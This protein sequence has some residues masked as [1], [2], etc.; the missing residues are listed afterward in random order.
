[1]E[2]ITEKEFYEKYDIKER[3]KLIQ[4][5]KCKCECGRVVSLK[6]ITRHRKQAP[7]LI[8]LEKNIYCYLSILTC[9]LS[10]KIVVP[11][12]VNFPV[13]KNLF[14]IN[15]SNIDLIISDNSQKYN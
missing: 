3:V 7:H 1:M 9:F 11:L 4:T 6:N 8:F 14:I 15:S 13:E 12:N 10:N 5:I 2:I